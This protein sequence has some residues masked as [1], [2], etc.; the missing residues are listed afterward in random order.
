MPVKK[1]WDILSRVNQHPRD[2]RVEFQEEGHK[3]RIDGHV[4]GWVS[5]TSLLSCLHRPFDKDKVVSTLMNGRRYKNGEHPLS[6]KSKDEILS[7]WESQNKRGTALHARMELSMQGIHIGYAPGNGPCGGSEAGS[8]RRITGIF[9]PDDDNKDNAS[10]HR[11]WICDMTSEVFVWYPFEKTQDKHQ[12]LL[13]IGFRWEDGTIRRNRAED[14]E[15]GDEEPVLGWGEAVTEALQV[16]EFWESHANPKGIVPYR[17]EWVIWDET[18]KIAGTIDALMYNPAT[19]G[20]LIYDWK[21]VSKGLEVDLDATRYGYKPGE[22]EWLNDVPRWTKR[23]LA[24][25]EVLYDTKYWHYSLQL[26][27]YRS[28]LERCYGLRI[29]GMVLVQIHPD[30]S[31]IRCHRVMH[32]EDPIMRV[33]E[34]RQKEL[35][36]Q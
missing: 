35:A 1:S 2:D 25:V 34:M 10:R 4:D 23:M 12:K 26:N 28:I 24:P 31:G 11:V 14:A 27:L 5:A 29:D 33:L 7:H 21:R 30:I 32:L 36:T 19:G 13:H 9:A 16:R 15:L 17:S 3:Y 22:D 6:G 18:Y 8:L 20:Y